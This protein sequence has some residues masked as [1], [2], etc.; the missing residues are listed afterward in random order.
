M[1]LNRSAPCKG[2]AEIRT[3]RFSFYEPILSCSDL[4]AHFD[5]YIAVG[6]HTTVVPEAAGQPFAAPTGAAADAVVA[7]Y[8]GAQ[9]AAR[10]IKVGAKV[11]LQ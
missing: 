3:L 9:I 10:M 2:A 1:S 7:A 4:G 8:Q 11:L 6:A 5:G